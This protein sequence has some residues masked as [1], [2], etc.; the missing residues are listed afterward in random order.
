MPRKKINT[1]DE[2]NTDEVVIAKKATKS[3]KP[4]KDE[5]D[6]EDEEDDFG[7]LIHSSIFL[8]ISSQKRWDCKRDNLRFRFIKSKISIKNKLRTSS[9]FFTTNMK[10]KSAKINARWNGFYFV[11]RDSCLL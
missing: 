11:S 2:F 9:Y 8:F 5:E 1:I 10:I 7:L 3:S 6:E 4:K